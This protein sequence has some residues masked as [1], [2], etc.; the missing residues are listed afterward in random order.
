V[1]TIT[2]NL[3]ELYLKKKKS[4]PPEVIL[5]KAL[6]HLRKGTPWT[7]RKGLPLSYKLSQRIPDLSIM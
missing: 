4:E 7:P 6:A 2:I 3:D 5:S 1:H